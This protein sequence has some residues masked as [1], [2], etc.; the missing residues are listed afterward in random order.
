MNFAD[1]TGHRR[2]F[3]LSV[4]MQAIVMANAIR[5]MSICAKLGP[6]LSEME[7]RIL[8]RIQKVIWDH[9]LASKAEIFLQFERDKGQ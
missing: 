6:N 8:V 3:N 4:S 5:E 7:F 9:L 1:S 2:S